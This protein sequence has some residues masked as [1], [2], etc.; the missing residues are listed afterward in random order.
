MIAYCWREIPWFSRI[1]VYQA[2]S[3]DNGR[4]VWCGFRPRFIMVKNIDDT[5]YQT[6]YNWTIFDTARKPY[7]KLTSSTTTIDHNPLYANSSADENT[8]T[9]GGAS[10]GLK[11]DTLSTG[12][13]LKSGSAEI[14]H[15]GTYV[16][17]ALAEHPSKLARAF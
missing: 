5:Q 17:L 1:G 15:G 11:I 9:Y 14:N 16:F 3:N 4:V 12:F 13:K 10:T 6:A 8:Y 2:T 7:N